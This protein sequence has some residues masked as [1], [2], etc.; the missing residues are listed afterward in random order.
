MKSI[1]NLITVPKIAVAAVVLGV[2]G[3]AV[4]QQQDNAALH[5]D[6]A[7]L[8]RRVDALVV[9]LEQS[10]QSEEASRQKLMA[11]VRDLQERLFQ[12]RATINQ[13]GAATGAPMGDPFGRFPSEGVHKTVRWGNQ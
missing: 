1:L 11:Q 8:Q 9:R 3:L 2:S 7:A 5:A 12:A 6:N 10:M 13:Y 4:K